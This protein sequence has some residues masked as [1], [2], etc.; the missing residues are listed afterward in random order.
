MSP[1][2]VQC[3]MCGSEAEVVSGR[4]EISVGRRRVLVNDE[5]TR[6]A[7]CDENFYTAEQSAALEA[8]AR[9]AAERAENCLNGDEIAEVRRG[10]GLTQQ[11]FDHLLGVGEK[12]SA[13][14]ESGKVRPNVA[15]DRLIRL[16]AADRNNARILAGIHGVTLPDSCFVPHSVEETSGYLG[17]FSAHEYSG[18]PMRNLIPLGGTQ[19]RDVVN[20]AEHE[21]IVDAATSPIRVRKLKS[22]GH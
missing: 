9:E 7:A 14:W 10:L 11:V 16:L 21:A 12:S 8:R 4:T 3:L 2:N 19:E 5:Y 18:Q 17:V 15:T 6:C 13:R 22:S 20:T 1:I